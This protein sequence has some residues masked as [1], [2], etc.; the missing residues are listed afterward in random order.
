MANTTSIIRY[1]LLIC[2]LSTPLLITCGKDDNPTGN[3]E[4]GNVIYNVTSDPTGARCYV[5]GADTG[6]IT[7]DTLNVSEGTHSLTLKLEDYEDWTKSYTAVDGDTIDVNATLNIKFNFSDDFEDGAGNWTAGC[8]Y[9]FIESGSYNGSNY[10][11]I[12]E[13]TDCSTQLTTS[14]DV[15]ISPQLQPMVTFYY[16]LATTGFVSGILVIDAPSAGGPRYVS[17]DPKTNW[18]PFQ[19]PASTLEELRG[20]TCTFSFAFSTSGTDTYRFSLDDF[21]LSTQ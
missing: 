6:K 12:T 2:L 18:T 1:G 19:V 17:L 14:F 21:S 8:P 5:D 20:A 4:T 10:V 13:D 3:G 11:Q 15:P 7:P 9:E 16:N